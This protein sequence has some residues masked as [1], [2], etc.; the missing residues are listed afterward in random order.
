MNKT[1]YIIDAVT[2][3][4]DFILYYQIVRRSDDAILAA[5]ENLDYL[6]GFAD[7]RNFNYCIA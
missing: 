4:R 7:G 2:D 1:P 5:S 6:I 3:N